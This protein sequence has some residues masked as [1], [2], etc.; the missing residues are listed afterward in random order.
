LERLSNLPTY[1]R[2]PGT[3]KN[4]RK[5]PAANPV[6]LDPSLAL[7]EILP[8]P[9]ITTLALMLT[10]TAGLNWLTMLAIPATVVPGLSRWLPYYKQLFRRPIDVIVRRLDVRSAA[11]MPMSGTD[12]LVIDRAHQLE[13]RQSLPLDRFHLGE[14]LS[15][16]AGLIASFRWYRPFAIDQ[17]ADVALSAADDSPLSV[18]PA[19]QPAGA[20]PVRG[21]LPAGR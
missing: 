1:D 17:R 18:Q 2:L 5:Q 13:E 6:T 8:Y 11:H 14:S 20:A 16:I 10:G 3:Q 9:I 19:P 12:K 21:G 15:A 4:Y 7:L